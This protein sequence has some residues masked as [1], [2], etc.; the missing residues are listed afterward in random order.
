MTD[1]FLVY[2]LCSARKIIPNRLENVFVNVHS[3]AKLW[4]EGFLSGRRDD[5]WLGGEESRS[6]P[7]S[8]SDL[9][10]YQVVPKGWAEG[11]ETGWDK[12]GSISFSVLFGNHYWHTPFYSWHTP[13]YFL[14]FLYESS[15]IGFDNKF[16][17][18]GFPYHGS[19]SSLSNLDINIK[20]QLYLGTPWLV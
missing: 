16:K 5:Q 9:R 13:Q 14:S 19:D 6:C 1:A 10:R 3:R 11:S 7:R 4:E 2:F 15:L 18:W 8:D 20:Y 12:C 17:N